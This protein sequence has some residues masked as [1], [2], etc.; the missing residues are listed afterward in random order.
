MHHCHTL[1]VASIEIEPAP[2]VNVGQ[3][4]VEDRDELIVGESLFRHSVRVV[5]ASIN[6]DVNGEMKVPGE[7]DFAS[8]QM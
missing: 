8:M 4:D 1:E 7:I 6:I 2:P 3:N 5:Q